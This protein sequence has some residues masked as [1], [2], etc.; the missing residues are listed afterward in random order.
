MAILKRSKKSILGL[1]IQLGNIETNVSN[2]ATNI[3]NEITRA[4]SAEGTLT[5]NLSNTTASITI[6]N[7]DN[8]TTGS[9]DKK[10]ADSMGS[11]ATSADTYT[12]SEVD[13]IALAKLDTAL[14]LTTA[15][16]GNKVATETELNLKANSADV[17]T[18]S[19]LDTSLAAKANQDTT[20]TKTESDTNISAKADQATTYTKTETDSLISPKANSADVYTKTE[21]DTNL[22]TKLNTSDTVSTVDAGNKIIT[23]T[24]LA[25]KANV[26][27]VYTQSEID[28]Q[29]AS[30][31]V[32][33][34]SLT[35]VT[36]SNK[37]VTET[38]LNLKANSADVYT[39]SQLDTALGNKAD[40]GVAGKVGPSLKLV[41]ETNIDDGK[42]LS[43][44]STSGNLEYVTAAD[45]AAS[46][47]DDDSTAL[48]ST[49][50]STKIN[51]DLGTKAPQSDT[52]T[53]AEVDGLSVASAFGI[54]YAVA[55]LTALNDLTGMETNELA[56]NQDDRK[57]Y[58]YDGS[59]WN[60]FYTLDST[61]NHNDLYYTK[62]ESDTALGLKADD[63][64][65]YTKA[66]S[67]TNLSTKANAADAGKVGPTLIVVDETNIADGKVLSYNTSTSQL[68][69]VTQSADGIL[70]DTTAT[71][72]TTY[73]S[74]K[75]VS[76]L[77]LK[78]DA[79]TTYDKTEVDTMAGNKVNVSD[80]KSTIAS[81][82]KVVTETELALKADVATTYTKGEVDTAVNAKV[83]TSDV[84]SA[85]ASDN[86]VVTQADV[87]GFADT[88]SVYT[89]TET[90][91][92]VA[93]KANTADVYTKTD[94]DTMAANKVNT[95]D[96]LTA[97]AADNKVITESDI[98]GLASTADTYTKVEVDAIALPKFDDAVAVTAVT[99]SNKLVTETELVLKVNVSDVKSTI[100][101]D[102]KVVTETDITQAIAASEAAA[103]TAPIIVVDRPT[104]STK[105]SDDL[106]YV[107]EFALS[108][109]PHGLIAVNDEITIYNF[110]ENGDASLFE[111]ISLFSDKHGEIAVTL[112]STDE[113]SKYLN[114]IKVCY[115]STEATVAPGTDA[116]HPII[117]DA[118]CEFE[119]QGS[120]TTAY[121]LDY[122]VGSF[123]RI[124]FTDGYYT[125]INYD[126]AHTDFHA[127]NDTD[128]QAFHFDADPTL[129]SQSWGGF[130]DEVE[131][132]T[133]NWTMSLDLD[134]GTV[135]EL[136][137]LR[138][139]EV[140]GGAL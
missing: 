7:A 69:Y 90:D 113:E 128:Y 23:Q 10:I 129:R 85:I 14:V 49:W 135:Y 101:V 81:D 56:V 138:G 20:Y 124:T 32:D 18:Q 112:G 4:Q 43:Y 38:E 25:L 70:D 26:S 48:D 78:A 100:A 104:M 36:S 11:L 127:N 42:V 2:A 76:D 103:A 47:I 3:S 63:G 68:E 22:L 16:A 102:N 114:T 6:L 89:K 107:F 57:V 52:Y 94:V 132:T 46:S 54:K 82:N 5:T 64:V 58:K 71:T 65:S 87:A 40:A 15:S 12:K 120:G 34:D 88:S 35:A 105:S 37:V 8:T 61:H 28:T 116:L 123:Y 73:S 55:D 133:Y 131:Y 1:D 99:A 140:G 136:S 74:N 13:A 122:A 66:E 92:L 125:N 29:N 111:N 9:I 24:E 19:Q 17:Y 53:K 83:N 97:I 119:K 62:T 72:T 86:K 126:L 110:E 75:I 93:P 44:N 31:L 45:P 95:A 51:N 84:L 41:D 109:T 96:V 21:S 98:A 130:D 79:A 50:S 33:S 106:D 118:G 137:F 108:R 30:N 27:D 139:D 59:N 115:L 134:T 77:A 91:N 80:V 39:Q 60:E 117:I 67:D 121:S